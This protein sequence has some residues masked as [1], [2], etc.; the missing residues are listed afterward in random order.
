MRTIR[1]LC[2]QI[3]VVCSLILITA[4]ILDWYNPYMDFSGHV[5]L[6]QLFLCADMIFLAVTFGRKRGKIKRR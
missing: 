1:F 6:A 2:T 4:R 5:V 3:G